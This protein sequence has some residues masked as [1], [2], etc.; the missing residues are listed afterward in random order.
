MTLEMA[1]PSDVNVP[2]VVGFFE[3]RAVQVIRDT[4]LTPK[5]SRPSGHPNERVE[6]QDPQD[7]TPASVGSTV[8][9]R[10]SR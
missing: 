1:G 5:V 10:L 4:G 3:G 6:T 2:D 8:M 7:D 9:L